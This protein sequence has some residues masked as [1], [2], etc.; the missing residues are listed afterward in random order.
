[1]FCSLKMER[2][3]STAITLSHIFVFSIVALGFLCLFCFWSFSRFASNKM[4]TAKPIIFSA[5]L[6]VLIQRIGYFPTLNRTSESIFCLFLFSNLHEFEVHCL[7]FI[8]NGSEHCFDTMTVNAIVNWSEQWSHTYTHADTE[9]EE[10]EKYKKNSK[11]HRNDKKE[12]NQRRPRTFLRCLTWL[13]KNVERF[14]CDSNEAW[15]SV[16]P[17]SVSFVHFYLNQFDFNWNFCCCDDWQTEMN[18]FSSR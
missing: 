7:K 14:V 6:F 17:T 12:A 13:S 11:F 15:S 16:T 10:K 8:I 2:N 1:M 5:F 18:G 4:P 9:T 3:G